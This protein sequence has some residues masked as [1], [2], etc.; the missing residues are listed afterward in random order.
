VIAGVPVQIIPVHND[1]ALEAVMQ[2]VDMDYDGIPVRVMKPEYLVALYLEESARTR[3]RL[4][5][6]EALLEEGTV[7]ESKLKSLVTRFKLR[8]P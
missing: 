5:R 1:L 4:A 8:L 2:A 6:V 3:K 7:D